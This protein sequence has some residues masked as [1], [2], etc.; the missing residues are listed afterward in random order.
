[1][2]ASE[3]GFAESARDRRMIRKLGVSAT[4]HDFVVM[5]IAVTIM[6]G[7][8]VSSTYILI[9][10]IPD[11]NETLVGQMQGALWTAL[12][13]LVSYYFGSNKTDAGK[14]QTINSLATTMGKVEDR[15]TPKADITVS[16]GETVTVAGASDG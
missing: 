6:V 4:V 14:D 12:G 5:G 1:M 10:P 2:G 8:I 9:W 7:V 15:K 11:R 3:G 13:M 16:E